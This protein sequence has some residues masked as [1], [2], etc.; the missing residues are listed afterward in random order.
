MVVAVR[1]LRWSL[2]GEAWGNRDGK[3]VCQREISVN[4]RGL[5][6]DAHFPFESG[7]PQT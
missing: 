6:F 5:C 3:G 7:I 2:I 4:V 1:I